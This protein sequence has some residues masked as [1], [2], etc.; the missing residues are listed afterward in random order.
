MNNGILSWNGTSPSYTITLYN[1]TVGRN[2][3]SNSINIHSEIVSSKSF[4][5]N[6]IIL[7]TGYTNKYY[8]TKILSLNLGLTKI[9]IISENAGN[10]S[11]DISGEFQFTVALP[12]DPTN[13]Q[14]NGKKKSICP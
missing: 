8:D 10:F 3:E 13:I 11:V 2:I 7:E 5:P 14:I 9:R 4:D 6:F 1:T 12:A